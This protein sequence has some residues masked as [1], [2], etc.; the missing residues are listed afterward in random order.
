MEKEDLDQ[1]LLDQY[2][3]CK[4]HHKKMNKAKKIMGD[5]PLLLEFQR[6]NEQ[7]TNF[8]ASFIENKSL[9]KTKKK[10]KKRKTSDL[11]MRHP[12]V[13][14][15]KYFWFVTMYGYNVMLSTIKNISVFNKKEK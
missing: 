9:L 11:L 7:R 15:Y 14:T 4:H 8:F 6:L 12:L 5:D 1:I 13:E 3:L 2:L 10:M